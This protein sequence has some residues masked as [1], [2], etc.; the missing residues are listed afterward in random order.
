MLREDTF[1]QVGHPGRLICIIG[2]AF[3]HR[4]EKVLHIAK[5]CTTDTGTTFA[6]KSTKHALSRESITKSHTK[7]NKRPFLKTIDKTLK[8]WRKKEQLAIY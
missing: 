5:W 6:R 3:P 4:G 1:T 8:K 2:V 7:L